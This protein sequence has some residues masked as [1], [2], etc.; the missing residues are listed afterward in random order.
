MKEIKGPKEWRDMPYSWI[1]RLTVVKMSNPPKLIYR[2]SALP[3][4]ILVGSFVFIDKLVLSLY[5]KAKELE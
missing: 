3:F 4:R 1:R 2:F 5:E